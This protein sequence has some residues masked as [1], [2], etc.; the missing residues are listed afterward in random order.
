MSSGRV[1]KSQ[2]DFA[3]ALGSECDER[4]Q[5]PSHR[6][7]IGCPLGQAATT[8]AIAQH[9]CPSVK[10]TMGKDFAAR[11]AVYVGAAVVL[12]LICGADDC[13]WLS[14]F[15]AKAKGAPAKA[16]VA[17]KYVT[18]VVLITCIAAGLALGY[19]EDRRAGRAARRRGHR[20]GCGR[21]VG[22]VR[23]VHSARGRLVP[24][25][26]SGRRGRRRGGGGGIGLPTL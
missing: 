10:E 15:L 5:F 14:P 16:K 1:P 13:V 22:A 21:A 7:P 24:L 26:P 23:S 20:H 12:K 25:L 3:A 18:T 6:R 19:S 4:P 11:H 17:A 2:G 9:G 8:T